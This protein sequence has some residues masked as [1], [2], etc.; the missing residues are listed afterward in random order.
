L[1]YNPLY[2]PLENGEDLDRIP[3]PFQGGDR[4]GYKKVPNFKF[5]IQHFM[6]KSYGQHYLKD[7][8]VVSK[9]IEAADLSIGDFVVEVGPGEG[10][11]TSE[12]ISNISPIGPI[13]PIL[14]E[15]D[16]DLISDLETN[17]SKAKV[18]HADAAQVDI[19]S[20][21]EDRPWIFISNLPYNAAN[22]I[23]MNMLTAKNPPQKSI[24]MVQKE[25]GNKIIAKPGDMS[26]L[27]VAAQIYTQPT[28][29]CNVKPG[30]FNPPPKV[31]SVV[32]K[33][34]PLDA[35]EN[36]EDII[37]LAKIGFSSR[38]KQLHRNLA[39][40]SIGTSDEIKKSLIE[41]E[42]KETARAQELSV[43]NWMK[44]YSIIL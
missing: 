30:S 28:R 8:S 31:D 32:L 39:N 36:A 40:A 24:I 25:V 11:L 13:R 10:A 34:E 42:L 37:K 26:V 5:Y 15:A 27:S 9:I 41:L 12:I 22:A 7:R 23:L 44:L 35:P 4:G 21:T 29:V 38:R 20:I 18:I 33:L 2:L 6:K 19:D 1:N 16:P 14:I 3:P 17:F 43:E